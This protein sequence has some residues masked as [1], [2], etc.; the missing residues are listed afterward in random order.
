MDDMICVGDLI[1]VKDFHPVVHQHN[2][3][4][5]AQSLCS[6]TS[7][8]SPDTHERLADL[9]ENYSI[10]DDL[11][12]QAFDSVLTAFARPQGRG[13]L[14]NGVF[15]SGKSHLLAVLLMLCRSE[16]AWNSFLRSHPE[17]ASRTQHFPPYS[18]W[19]A[20]SFSLDAYSGKA[21]DLES[22]FWSETTK[23]L[24]GVE[25]EVDSNNPSRSCRFNWLAE[26]LRNQNYQGAVWLVDE[27]SLFLASKRR[28]DL[29]NDASFLQYVGQ[30]CESGPLYFVGAIQKSV[31]DIG[32]FEP[33]ILEQIKERYN[34]R[35]TLQMA[36]TATLMRNRIVEVADPEE[37]RRRVRVLISGWR[38][39]FPCF[40][41]GDDDLAATYP[42]HPVTLDVLEAVVG[43]FFSRTRSAL[44][45]AHEMLLADDY[46]CQPYAAIITP[47]RV[48]DYF[49]PDLIAHPELRKFP[50]EVFAFYQRNVSS[51]CP[52]S[53]DFALRL[54]KLLIL[55]K[56]G[57]MQLTVNQLTHALLADF[58]LPGEANYGFVRYVLEK[59]RT[60]GN[61]VTTQKSSMT[62]ETFYSIDLGVRINE[63]VRH[64]IEAV[65][66]TLSPEDRRVEQR[67]L[68]CC[69]SEDFPIARILRPTSFP[70]WWENTERKLSAQWL[71][72][73]SFDPSSMRHSLS[74][75]S[76]PTS[77]E[78]GIVFVGSLY[79]VDEQ[80]ER[81]LE[82]MR[83]L[84][85]S[86]GESFRRWESSLACLLPRQPTPEETA[87]LRELTACHLLIDDPS[88]NDNR[89]GRAILAR[90]R[91]DL[92]GQVYEAQR[93]IHNAYLQGEAI[94]GQ[95]IHCRTEELVSADQTWLY[96]MDALAHYMF[97]GVFPLFP[98]VSP[99]QRIL[100]HT[101]SNNLV[102]EILRNG[103]PGNLVTPSVDRLARTIGLPLGLFK[104]TRKGLRFASISS[105][106]LAQ[107]EIAVSG[108]S[109]YREAE[110]LLR[111]SE[112]GLPSEL[113]QMVFAAMLRQGHFV[114]LDL[115]SAV[116]PV[117]SIRSPLRDSVARLK[118]GVLLSQEQWNTLC[119]RMTAWFPTMNVLPR[120]FENQEKYWSHLCQ[121]REVVSEQLAKAT[122]LLTCLLQELSQPPTQWSETRGAISAVEQKLQAIQLDQPT[123]AGLTAWMESP[124]AD[125]CPMDALDTAAKSLSFLEQSSALLIGMNR[126][127]NEVSLPH[128]HPLCTGRESLLA[129]L[130][131]GETVMVNWPIVKREWDAFLSEYITAYVAWHRAQ[132][133]PDRVASYLKLRD[134]PQVQQLEW[135]NRV[136]LFAD[137]QPFSRIADIL[138]Q[139][140]DCPNLP[141]SLVHSPRC[142]QCRRNLSEVLDAPSPE[143]VLESYRQALCERFARLCNSEVVEALHKH[144]RNLPVEVQKSLRTIV[145]AL[146]K[147]DMPSF[148]AALTEES[149]RHINLALSPRK[150]VWRRS[151][152]IVPLLAGQSLTKH[153]A[154]G[155]FEA[156]LDGDEGLRPGDEVQF[157]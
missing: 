153:N 157:E 26:H 99:K 86:S 41:D 139:F 101:G 21:H 24:P 152:E 109:T 127:L 102:T 113:S 135:I 50:E 11:N 92:P 38:S 42:V 95:L 68:C 63:A 94:V 123:S 54:I 90:L 28:E 60:E 18:K 15:G 134:L 148:F 16:Q 55:L 96:L 104:E 73:M 110:Q 82:G 44:L 71:D 66:E 133:A 103:M 84:K 77:E 2:I 108:T 151:S 22:V 7:A 130:R 118:R 150:R 56:I 89:R 145:E 85:E 79:H 51:L 72:L 17:Y 115:H 125:T 61:F 140:C 149:L 138:L 97:R 33:Y 9:L 121:W 76:E 20:V 120:T 75:I 136:T 46:L 116:V 83:S 43:R 88:L 112:S 117:E 13:F 107:C 141:A 154:I 106:L 69:T 1:R 47:E 147:K 36:Q 40:P 144:T 34:T 78:D 58:D 10:Q 62:G 53:P 81:W 52:E 6:E 35:L 29:Q 8:L 146:A 14:I 93:L 12:R 119:D 131:S 100:S 65:L 19:L 3:N 5:L 67:A 128:D 111:K 132:N 126:Y 137:C 156:W 25:I 45:F 129:T 59:F 31:E 48:F 122:R 105:G 91:E 142:H 57:N 49:L 80:R 87:R 4:A 70:V 30:R 64:R 114:A 124:V 23:A 143:A 155:R 27:L 74:L 98:Q 39:A 37:L 32:Q